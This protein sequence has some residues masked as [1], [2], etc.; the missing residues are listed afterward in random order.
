MGGENAHLSP[1]EGVDTTVYLSTLPDDGPT[2]LFFR[3]RAPILW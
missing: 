2:G 3:K 1:E